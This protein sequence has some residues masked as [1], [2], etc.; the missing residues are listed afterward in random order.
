[1]SR[2]DLEQSL[3]GLREEIAKLDDTDAAKERLG[4]LLTSLERQLDDTID[5]DEDDSVAEQVQSQIE[6]FEV[7]HPHVTAILNRIMVTLS[8][9]GI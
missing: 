5:S 7:E 6:H 1:M 9:M 8:N 4:A 2:E 3:D